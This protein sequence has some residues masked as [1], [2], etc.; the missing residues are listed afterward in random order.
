MMNDERLRH[1]KQREEIG[2]R[3][4]GRSGGPHFLFLF[5]VLYGFSEPQRGGWQGRLRSCLLF[6]M[7]CFFSKIGGIS[8]EY[9]SFTVLRCEHVRVDGRTNGRTV[10]CE[11][12]LWTSTILPLFSPHRY[13]YLSHPSTSPTQPIVLVSVIDDHIIQHPYTLHPKIPTSKE[14]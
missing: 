1:R 2:Y 10:V 3:S 11:L 9:S 5:L 7:S 4:V 14:D 12:L 8:S 6:R 13:P